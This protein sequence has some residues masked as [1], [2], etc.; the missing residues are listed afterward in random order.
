MKNLEEVQEA[1]FVID[2]NNG[3]CEEG[4][5]ADPTIKNIVPN[6]KEIIKEGLKRKSGLFFVNDKHTEESVELK[7]Y[8]GHCN[9]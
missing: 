8:A 2:M 1:I 3:F 9:T 6:I 7:R 4:A 5:L